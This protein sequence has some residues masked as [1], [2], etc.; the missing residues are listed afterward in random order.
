M[1]AVAAILLLA[2]ASTATALEEIQ[3]TDTK[4][5]DV[6][7]ELEL[8]IS[9]I[10]GDISY[11]VGRGTEATVEIVIDV[12]ADDEDE[13]Q[14]IRELIDISVEGGRGMLEASVEYPDDFSRD[15]RREFGKKRSI[16]VSFL[17]TG[18]EEAN[19]HFASVSGDALVEGLTGPVEISTVS[20]HVIAKR[21]E[22][23]ISAGSVSG[24]VDVSDCGDRV[25]A[26]SVSGSVHVEN[27][28]GDVKAGTV[29]GVVDLFGISGSVSVNTTSGDV[30]AEH[31][32]GDM[33]IETVSGDVMARSESSEGEIDVESMSG[34]VELFADKDKIGRIALSTFSG[35]IHM[36]N[37][38]TGKKKSRR[39][40][41]GR[42]DLHLT[43]GNGDLDVRAT[44]HSG[45]IWVRE[46]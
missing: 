9:T 32:S 35:D 39:G 6:G 25:S 16:S 30:S 31:N 28:G 46:L 20:G 29:S 24:D 18:P 7:N 11:T 43:L 38:P 10:S 14:E 12:R 13:A 1:A 36:K 40:F 27:C 21:V 37:A 44:T 34:S 22:R 23:R 33:T 8:D 3:F 4:T 42:G 19:G 17:I 5:F 15:L 45:D 41:D 2:C 26:N